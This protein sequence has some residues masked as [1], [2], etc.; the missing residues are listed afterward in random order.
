[1][2]R[3]ADTKTTL[4]IHLQ[5][6]AKKSEI[7]GFRGNVLWVKVA[8]PPE[9]GKANDALIELLSGILSLPKKDLS[10]VRGLT[11]RQKV[12]AV[13]SMSMETMR[14]KLARFMPDKQLPLT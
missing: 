10:L 14:S 6:G 12:V 7:V 2:G 8:A 3:M 4:E 1:M 11:S 5:P 9:K 13:S